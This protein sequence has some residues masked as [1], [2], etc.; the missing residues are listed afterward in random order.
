MK[1][2]SLSEFEL[3]NEGF[4]VKLKRAIGRAD[5]E[6]EEEFTD[7]PR[8][9]ARAG[10]K[11]SSRVSNP[12]E[13]EEDAVEASMLIEV[14]APMVGTF[15]QS[16]SPDSAPFVEPGTHVNADTV[17]CFVEAMYVM[18]DIKAEV[19]GTVVEV[20]ATNGKPVE[21]GQVLFRIKPN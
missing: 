7:T 17:F 16:P 18:N 2:N 20:A 6:V 11:G 1:L 4:K 3:E 9:A 10:R 13:E 15:Y 5:V 21:F 14:K 19:R 8:V 12:K